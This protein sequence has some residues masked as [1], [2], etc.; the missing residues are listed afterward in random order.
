MDWSKK[1]QTIALIISLLSLLALSGC[2]VVDGLKGN[3]EESTETL[4]PVLLN[5]KWGYIN[6]SGNMVIE[7]DFDEARAFSDGFAAVRQ[8]TN[9]GY[10]SEN[11]KT[12]AIP[13]S[14]SVAGDFSGELAPAQRPGQSYGFINTSGDFVI[15]PEFDFAGAFSEGLAAVRSDGLWGYVSTTGNIAIDLVFSDAQSFSEDVA[16]VETFEGWVYIDQSG[17]EQINP[18]FQITAAGEFSDG[19][20]PIQTTEGWG[21][22]DKT[23]NPVITPNFDEAGTFSQ[24]LAWVRNDDYIGFINKSGDITIPYQFAEVKSFSENMS[25]VRVSGDWFYIN[26]KSGLIVIKE[27]FFNAESFYNG[28]ALV[29]IGNNENPRFGYVNK[30]GEYIWYPTR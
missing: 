11:T 10:V 22:I 5:G 2:T 29:Q 24:G 6:T 15:A 27:P 7:P 3:D 23:G 26:R 20:A 30:A 4:H 25:A 16:A 1:L 8:G 9:W 14:F 18:D 19:M 21:Y 13:V 17:T 12:L 28:I